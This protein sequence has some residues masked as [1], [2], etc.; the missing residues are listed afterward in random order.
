MLGGSVTPSDPLQ[1][2]H[3]P[4]KPCHPSSAGEMQSVQGEG[5]T[6][7]HSGS[8]E[9]AAFG[10]AGGPEDCSYIYHRS[11]QSDPPWTLL[12]RNHIHRYAIPASYTPTL[13]NHTL[14]PS[15]PYAITPSILSPTYDISHP[16]CY[17]LPMI[18]HT[19][20]AITPSMLS[21]L[22]GITLLCPQLGGNKLC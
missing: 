4:I 19:L 18:Y 14:T 16:L 15:M 22:Y 6:V 1:L 13:S 5:E 2:Q 7:R 11:R 3:F 17:H 12:P 20:Y 21:P 8:A 9:N 10:S